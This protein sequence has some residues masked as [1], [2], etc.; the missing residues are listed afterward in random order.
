VGQYRRRV[1]SAGEEQAAG[2]YTAQGYDVLARNW[3]CHEGEID[4]VVARD[5]TLVFVEV[6]SRSS[7]RFGSPAEAVTPAK[8]RRLR[9]LAGRYLATTGPRAARVR[10]DVVSILAG[11]LDVYEAAF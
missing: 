8:Q 5:S 6:K 3:R 7:D 1:G 11:R 10:F 9:R 2:W 4:L